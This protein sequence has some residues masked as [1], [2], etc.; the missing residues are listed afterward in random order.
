MIVNFI[1]NKI[2]ERNRYKI[3]KNYEMA[4]KIRAELL[5]RGIKIK[6][7]REGTIYEI[8]K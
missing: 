1:N 2:E 7:T 6:D 8:V 3:E 4:D 5:D